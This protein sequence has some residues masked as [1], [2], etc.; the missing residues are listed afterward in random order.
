MAWSK[1]ISNKDKANLVTLVHKMTEAKKKKMKEEREKLIE[2]TIRN[3]MVIRN[4]SREEAEIILN[5]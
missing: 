3:I 5:K 2:Q 4:V 1:N